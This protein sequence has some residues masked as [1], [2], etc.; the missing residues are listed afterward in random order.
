[1]KKKIKSKKCLGMDDN[2]DEDKTFK[3]IKFAKRDP[4]KP[5]SSF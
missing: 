1:M 4:L 5:V 3:F 2:D